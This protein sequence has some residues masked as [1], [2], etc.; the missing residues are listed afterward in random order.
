MA[1][2]KPDYGVPAGYYRD[3]RGRLKKKGA[4]TPVQFAAL[5]ALNAREAGRR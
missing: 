2:A 5:R 4:S 1:A 3:Q